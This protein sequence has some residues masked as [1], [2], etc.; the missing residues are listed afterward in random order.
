MNATRDGECQVATPAELEQLAEAALAEAPL[1]WVIVKSV[2][3]SRTRTGAAR[4]DVWPPR[5]FVPWPVS[6][7]YRLLV[8]VHEVAHAKLHWGRDPRHVEEYE[9]E[10]F[11]MRWARA[12]ALR[13]PKKFLVGARENVCDRIDEDRKRGVWIRPSIE[14]WANRA[15]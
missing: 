13:V 11:A 6:D 10:Q 1:R 15:S 14:R 12:H 8:L 3:H 2:G 4:Y 5:L 7:V 9:A